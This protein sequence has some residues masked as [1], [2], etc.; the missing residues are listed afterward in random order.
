VRSGGGGQLQLLDQ[1]WKRSRSSA[2]S[3]ESALVPMI[4]H[5]CG[6]EVARQLSGVCPPYCT[7]TPQGPFPCRRSR[8]V[9]E[10]ERLE[11]Q[12]VGGVES[13]DSLRVAVDHDGLEAVLAQRMAACTQQ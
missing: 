1:F 2:M 3:I 5:A 11:V 6:G 8:H 10:R 4:G 13:V 12:T 7:I 9:F